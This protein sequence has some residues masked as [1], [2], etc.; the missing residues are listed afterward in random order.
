ML[1][2]PGVVG[3]RPE[4]DSASE[5]E[6]IVT[7]LMGR[8]AR[9]RRAIKLVDRCAPEIPELAELWFGGGRAQ[10]VDQ[11]ARHLSRRAQQGLLRTLS[12]ESHWTVVARTLV[13][14]CVL[15]A[16]HLEWDPAPHAFRTTQRVAVVAGI[17][18]RLFADG[19]VKPTDPQE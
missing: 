2:V 15:W 14:S 8:L 7:D 4:D 13:E 11:L 16:V 17:L 6:L 3:P 1:V 19:L 10:L 9:H 18:A 5:I 12:D